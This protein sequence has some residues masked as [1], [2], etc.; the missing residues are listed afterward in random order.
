MR[1]AILGGGMAGLT[2]SHIISKHK[3]HSVTLF[4]G[5]K[6]LGGLASGF[7]GEGWQWPLERAYHHIFSSDRHIIGFLNE[8]GYTD[9]I[10]SK[11]ITASLY[12]VEDGYKT[13][14]IDTPL[15]LL[16]F[17][18]LGMADKIRA[19][20]TLGF[21]K[22][23]PF[24]AFYERYTT[25]RLLQVMM[26]ERAYETLF[27]E[28]FRKKFGKYAG[29]IL[30]SFIWSRIHMRTKNLGYMQGGFQGMIDH[31][32]EMCRESGVLIRLQSKVASISVDTHNVLSLTT[33][34]GEVGK[35]DVVISTLPSPVLAQVASG[36]LTQE[37]QSNLHKIHHL[38]AVNLILE[39]DTPI[40]E[41]EYWVSLCTPDIPGLVFV[42]HTNF[43]DRS[44][45]NGNHILYIA[46]YCQD[47]DPR[48]SMSKEELLALYL[49]SLQKIAKNQFTI[50]QTHIWKA[51]Y[52]QPIFDKDFLSAVPHF[53][54]SNPR[55]FIANLDM[56]Y[57]FDRGTNYAVKLGR[58]VA[59]LA[60]AS[61][62]V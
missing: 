4:E 15:D 34:D 6:T 37:E 9:I 11:P 20:L 29:N 49:P 30:A 21:F 27:G 35:Y 12:R 53:A 14:A 5:E 62:G 26:G 41:N 36:V 18:L 52:A 56:T 38:S 54:T 61:V 7:W 3:Q 22:L 46:S 25:E 23:S 50:S 19:G 28:M 47:N 17:P 39:M 40:F 42:Q 2:A 32:G 33:G 59:A 16:R 10:F 44:R 31:V 60:L 48:M 43:V 13:F 51:R 55:F 8:L 58:D 45:Y 24:H 57:P 1:I